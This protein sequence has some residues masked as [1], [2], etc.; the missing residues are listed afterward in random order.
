M[1]HKNASKRTFVYY[2][3][4]GVLACVLLIASLY[5]LRTKGAYHSTENVKLLRWDKKTSV[6]NLLQWV[7]PAPAVYDDFFPQS[8]QCGDVWR[9]KYSRLHSSIVNG[10]APARYLVSVAVAKGTADRVTGFVTQFYLA[11]LSG[12]AFTMV[13][14]GDLPPFEAACDM[15]YFNWTHPVRLDEMVINPLI[16]S[17][18][19]PGGIFQTCS[20]VTDT[21]P[22]R[23]T[24]NIILLL[25]KPICKCPVGQGVVRR[26]RGESLECHDSCSC[27]LPVTPEV[28]QYGNLP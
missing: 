21:G 20:G 10:E 2:R 27:Y 8:K 11:L 15:P 26:N 12:R 13:T 25:R 3:V 5:A 23:L 18:S 22:Y 19:P 28:L 14:Y 9:T 16:T 1:L 4:L 6:E 7:P 24:A 17:A